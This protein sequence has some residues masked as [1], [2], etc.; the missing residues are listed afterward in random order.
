MHIIN[1]YDDLLHVLA[2]SECMV[3][4]APCCL[5]N[6]GLM[7]RQ[8]K[9]IARIAAATDRVMITSVDPSL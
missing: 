3:V 2:F 6:I 1:G 7:T 4:P 8:Q 5:P 9:G